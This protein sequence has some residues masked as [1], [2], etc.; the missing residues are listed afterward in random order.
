MEATVTAQIPTLKTG[1]L[2]PESVRL[3]PGIE[4]DSSTPSY[5]SARRYVLESLHRANHGDI[6]DIATAEVVLIRLVKSMATGNELLL[7][8]TERDQD[9]SVSTH[10][11][12]VAIIAMQI[13]FKL[14]YPLEKFIDVGMAALLHELG[15]VELPEELLHKSGK[16]TSEEL[17]MVQGRTHH[18]TRILEGIK[19]ANRLAQIVG[20]VYEREDGSGWPEGLRKKEISEEARVLGIADFFEA[21][22][23]PRPYRRARTGYQ[24]LRTLTLRQKGNFSPK[25]VKALIS[26]FSMYP[27]NELVR[28]NTQQVGKVLNIHPENSC[29]PLVTILSDS[30]GTK[31]KVPR[32]VDL[33]EWPNLFI[34]ESLDHADWEENGTGE[35]PEF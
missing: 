28:L 22:I 15:V 13:A 19:G 8:A 2:M 30:K 29:R 11:V 14:N 10:S 4:E 17:T 21:F 31:L 33:R 9:F 26:S 12:N 16:F 23:H 27:Y 5:E 34:T 32:L 35:L 25:I 20:Q 18:S 3:S 6:P 7:R 24:C 1:L